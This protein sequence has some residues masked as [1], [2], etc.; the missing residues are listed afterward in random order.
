MK[1]LSE[2]TPGTIIE[3]RNEDNDIKCGFVVENRAGFNY[4]II[5]FSGRKISVDVDKVE[6]VVAA[7]MDEWLN[8]LFTWS[9]T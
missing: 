6:K 5:T 2:L 8:S 1:A 9:E 3:Y 4:S 7:N